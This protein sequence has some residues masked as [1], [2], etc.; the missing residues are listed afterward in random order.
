MPFFQSELAQL[1]GSAPSA[2]FVVDVGVFSWGFPLKASLL[3][4]PVPVMLCLWRPATSWH[5]AAGLAVLPSRYGAAMLGRV[6]T[7]GANCEVT[8]IST[9]HCYKVLKLVMH[10][11]LS[12]PLKTGPLRQ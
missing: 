7:L 10:V 3:G 5:R 1:L 12:H 2:V 6:P 11:C 9:G 8:L 4:G